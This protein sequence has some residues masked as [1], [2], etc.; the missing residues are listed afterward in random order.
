MGLKVSIFTA[1]LSLLI[2]CKKG[3][4]VEDTSAKKGENIEKITEATSQFEDLEG[5]PIAIA[6]YKGKRVLLNYWAT[7]CR[8]CIEEMPSL[9]RSQ[10]ILEKENYI[11]LL[12][13]DQTLEVIKDFKEKRNFDFKY[14]KYKGSWAEEQINSLPTTYIYN[15]EGEKVEKI[16]GGVVWDSPEVLQ[17]L[18]E[19]H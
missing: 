12:A 6:D 1:I 15:E 8:P 16:I 3:V 7:W 4:K 19:T 18:K 10:A 2:S 13:S 14:I 9:L 17:K 11:F 5:N